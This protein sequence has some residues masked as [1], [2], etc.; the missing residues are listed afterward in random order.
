[1]GALSPFIRIRS[2]CDR[3]RRSM[4][5]REFITLVGGAATWPLAARAQR[6]TRPVI[7][8]LAG[9]SRETTNV[10]PFVKGLAEL[11]LIEGRDFVLEY[12]GAEDQYERL[13]ELA[14]DLV[15]R[16]V[17]VLVSVGTIQTTLAAKNATSTIPIVFSVG[18]DPVQQGLVASLRRPGGNMTGTTNLN[19]EIGAKRPQWLRETIPMAKRFALLVNPGNADTPTYVRDGEAA[20]RLRGFEL[21]V[22]HAR[23]KAE[24]EPVF[25]TMAQMGIEGL[26]IGLDGIFVTYSDELGALAAR[27]AI[28][29]IFA[30][31]EFPAGGGL[32]SYGSDRI[33]QGRLTGI[34]DGRVLKGEKPDDRTVV[35]ASQVELVSSMED[36]GV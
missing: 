27:H 33:D 28:P 3:M 20:A 7:G 5:R 23:S 14:A 32:M 24:F 34:Y 1:M 18:V 10:V 9:G 15:R 31:R 36:D 26:V 17:A 11:G 2:R 35:Q 25:A 22:L 16:R 19:S 12:R 8:Y 21:H 13:P 30:F 4:R 29:G 6:G